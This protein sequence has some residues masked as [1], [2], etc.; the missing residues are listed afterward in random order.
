MEYLKDYQILLD[1]TQFFIA[2]VYQNCLNNLLI[3][4]KLIPCEVFFPSRRNLNL[5]KTVK[6]K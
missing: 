1:H 6:I 2:L 3:K 5:S 4:T